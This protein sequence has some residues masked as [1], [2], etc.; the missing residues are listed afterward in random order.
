MPNKLAAEKSPYLLQHAENPVDWYP[1]GPEALEQA[2]AHDLPILV[3]IG[4][5]ACHW[6]HVMAHE[7]FEDP[8]TARLMNERFISIKVDREERPDVDAIYMEAVQALTGQGGWPLNVFLLPDGR[9]FFGGTYFP[10]EPRH[11][12]PSWPQVLES[13]SKAYYERRADVLNNADELTRFLERS[14][15]LSGSGDS[16]TPALLDAAFANIAATWDWRAG[17]FGGSPKFPQPLALEFI[18]RMWSRN[19]YP[20]GLQFV[21][22]TLDRMASGGIFDQLGGGFHRYTVDG[23]WIV[24]HFEKMLYDNALLARVYT[25]AWQAT[26]DRAHREVAEQTLDYLLREMRAPRGAFFSAQDADS[27]GEEGKY[28][29]WTLNELRTVLGD[30]AEIVALRY[31]VQPGGNFEGK[32]ILTRAMSVEDTAARLEIRTD[33]AE[34]TL[35]RARVA[36]LD[37]RSRRVPPATDTKILLAWNA[38]VIRALAEAARAFDRSDYLAAADA[39]ADFVLH[40]MSPGGNLVRSFND[41]ASDVPAFLEDYAYLVEALIGLY[42]ASFDATRLH[43]AEAMT[44]ELLGRFRDP[45][46]GLLF[47]AQNSGGDLI[48]R[49]RSLFDNPIPSGNSSAALGL[50]R[51]AA[52]TGDE[53]HEGVARS[54]LA[55]GTSIL[56]RAPL[57]AGYLLNALD[58]Y[59]STPLQIAI[60]GEDTLERDA[61]IDTVFQ[62]YIPDR[63][64]SV[65]LPGDSPLLANRAE[66]DGR[67]TAYVCE[68][69]ACQLPVTDR[70]TFAAQLDQRTVIE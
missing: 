37:V 11:G 8:V 64:L 62:R 36:L 54:I 67:A 40:D 50:L 38:L 34:R 5:S 13:V 33:E 24:P 31:G 52:L 30:D 51:L 6:C 1:W 7:S 25:L 57:S 29:V 46:S 59:L 15:I 49:P 27:E 53:S 35:N 19:G 66:I 17:G 23:A 14:Q 70:G 28:Y 56:E 58:F 3:S 26:H 20:R 18:L 9:P 32:S 4:Y 63:V 47:D 39:A 60:V 41:G 68:H 44:E 2:R 45:A 10:P 43:Q 42:E 16:L 55:S 48:V 12:L 22:L 65:G 61:L 69:F 21:K